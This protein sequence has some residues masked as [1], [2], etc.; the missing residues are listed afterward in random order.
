MSSLCSFP[1]SP[2][3]AGAVLIA[4]SQDLQWSDLL[5]NSAR[6]YLFMIVCPLVHYEH[7]YCNVIIGEHAHSN[8]G[9]VLFHSR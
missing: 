9:C 4:T 6:I 2:V 8:R 1:I 7:A 3:L 5:S